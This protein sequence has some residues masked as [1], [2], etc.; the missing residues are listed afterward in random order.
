M[1]TKNDPG[2]GGSPAADD[3]TEIFDRGPAVVYV[4]DASGKLGATYVSPNFESQFG[5]KPDE[6]IGNAD[7]WADHIHPEDTARVF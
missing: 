1:T 2:A 5:Y 6:F 7:F 3:L 4:T